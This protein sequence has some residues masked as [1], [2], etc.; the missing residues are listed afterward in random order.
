[1]KKDNAESV[2]KCLN[3]QHMKLEYQRPSALLQQTSILEWKCDVIATE[4]ISG[5]PR[6]SS[7]YNAIRVIVD[8]LTKHS[9][10]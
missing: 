3:C 10:A 4:F 1:M 9:V 7:G 6:T 8:K 2:S 5:L